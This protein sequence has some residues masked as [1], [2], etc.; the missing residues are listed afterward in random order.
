[1]RIEESLNVRFDESPSPK[2]SP[3]VD[4]DIIKSQ[5]IENQIEEIED[6]KNGPL[7]IRLHFLFRSLV[8]E[9]CCLGNSFKVPFACFMRSWILTRY[10]LEAATVRKPISIAVLAVLITGV[11][12]SRQHGKSESD[13]Y[14]LF[15]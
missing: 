3:L 14:Y 8:L 6:K 11:S 1:M 4:D 7:R 13:S 5:I 15:D 2:S 9:P 12:Q 10:G